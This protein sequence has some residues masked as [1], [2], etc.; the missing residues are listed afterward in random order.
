MNL[1]MSLQLSAVGIH[2]NIERFNAAA[3]KIA[4]PDTVGQVEPLVEMMLARHGAQANINTFKVAAGMNR[5][6]LDMMA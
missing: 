4:R 1:S 5:A 3:T 2:R 6:A